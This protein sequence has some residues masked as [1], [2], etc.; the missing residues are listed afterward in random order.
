MLCRV[1]DCRSCEASDQ[2]DVFLKEVSKDEKQNASA[3][4]GKVRMSCSHCSEKGQV[5]EALL[6]IARRVLK[7]NWSSPQW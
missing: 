7:L 4:S 6:G 5:N 2:S 3:T 1:I